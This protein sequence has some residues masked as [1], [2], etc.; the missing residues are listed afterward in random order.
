MKTISIV[1][2]TVALVTGLIAAQYWYRSS[3]VAIDPGWSGPTEPVLPELQQM[4]WTVAILKAARD[5]GDL[6]KTASLWTATS[7]AF[8]AASAIIGALA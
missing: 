1:L 4:G 8:G 2:A 5:V 6:N 3:K 7:V